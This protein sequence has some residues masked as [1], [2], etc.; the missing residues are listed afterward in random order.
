VPRRGGSFDTLTFTSANQTWTWSWTDG[1]HQ[2]TELYDNANGGR[3]T[4]VQDQDGNGLTFTYNAAGLI[5][6]VTD[7]NGRTRSSITPGPI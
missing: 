6:Q 4:K 7:A 5:T 3:I 2:L 1:T